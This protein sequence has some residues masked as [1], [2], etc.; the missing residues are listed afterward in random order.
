VERARLGVFESWCLRISVCGLVDG[1]EVGFGEG[2]GIELG[3][4]LLG[5]EIGEAGEDFSWDVVGA[6]RGGDAGED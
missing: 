2:A 3:G 4:P 5:G 1:E 6:E